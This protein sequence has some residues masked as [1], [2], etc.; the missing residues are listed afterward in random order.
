MRWLILIVVLACMSC[1]TTS[2]EYVP[3]ESVK[4]EFRDVFH[5]DSVFIC[6]SV[7]VMVKGDTIFR[8]RWRVEYRDRLRRDTIVRSDSIP[9]PYP[10]ERKLSK[11]EQTK[12]NY[13]GYA[14]GCTFAVILIVFGRLI[15]KIKK[16]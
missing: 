15:Y 8:D 10:V 2:V 12:I 3:V 14:L 7:I 6:D 13:G 16:G 11:W 4:T 5:R 9:L 1:R